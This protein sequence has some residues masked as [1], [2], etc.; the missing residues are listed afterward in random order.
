MYSPSAFRGTG[1][2]L[3]PELESKLCKRTEKNQSEYGCL[4]AS[5]LLEPSCWPQNKSV[6]TLFALI[7][8]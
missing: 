6:A 4:K 5:G 2:Q 1:L 3:E 7:L 8:V